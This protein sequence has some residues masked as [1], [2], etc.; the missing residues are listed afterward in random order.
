MADFLIFSGGTAFKETARELARRGCDVQYLI[1]TFDSGGSSQ[2]LRQAFAM[3]AVGDL[4]NRLLAIAQDEAAA[5]ALNARLSA[6]AREA[7]WEL[8][9]LDLPGRLAEVEDATRK[10]IEEDLERVLAAL[11]GD[12]QAARASLGNLALTGAWLKYGGRLLPAVRRYERLLRCVGEVIPICEYDL[13][14]AARLTNGQVV[15]HQHLFS[16]LPAPVAEIFLTDNEGRPCTPQAAPEVL[17]AIDQAKIIFYPMGSFY[18]SILPNFLP[19]GV[20]EALARTHVSKI[21]IPNVGADGEVGQ[22]TI[23]EQV[24]TLLSTLA[25]HGQSRHN[26]LDKKHCNF[27]DGVLLDF[28]GNYPGGVTM[29]LEKDLADL[30]V[31][32]LLS[33]IA[34]RRNVHNPGTLADAMEIVQGAVT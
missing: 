7:A 9:N 3:P 27:L 18:S 11:P 13:Q 26:L 29:S 6:D 12:F 23:L 34:P 25:H 10:A 5:Q 4:R 21:F 22:M 28:D 17:A 14:L 16:S 19:E 24:K 30:G 8:R 15:G 32:V 2:A 20:A 33:S 31:S 1:T